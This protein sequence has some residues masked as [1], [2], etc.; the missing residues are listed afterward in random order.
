MAASGHA[1]KGEGRGRDGAGRTGCPV[2]SCPVLSCPV[3]SCPVMS[4]QVRRKP[5]QPRRP[6]R[7]DTPQ[8]DG[9]DRVDGL[10]AVLTA[11]VWTGQDKTRKTLTFL[12][13]LPPYLPTHPPTYLPTYLPT[14]RPT[15][16]PSACTIIAQAA[17][18]SG[19][20]ASSSS[21]YRPMFQALS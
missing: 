10:S 19:L 7:L 1:E 4:S 8:R 21:S 6:P 12:L 2:L 3:L 9:E 18:G 13:L 16:R 11:F 20:R 17:A 5:C 14:Y 15:D